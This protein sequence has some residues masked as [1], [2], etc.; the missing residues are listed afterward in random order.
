VMR[1]EMLQ[2]D[3]WEGARLREALLPSG[4]RSAEMG[5][6]RDRKLDDGAGAFAGPKQSLSMTTGDLDLCP[7]P[8]GQSWPKG[9]KE[10][11]RRWARNHIRRVATPEWR[12]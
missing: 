5:R 11:E 2:G 12:F 8:Q 9:D 10:K 3:E 1:S 6:A 7:W 4:A